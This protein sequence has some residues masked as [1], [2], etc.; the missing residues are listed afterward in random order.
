MDLKLLQNTAILSEKLIELLNVKPK[1]RIKIEYTKKDNKLY[2]IIIKS[3]A[4]NVLS[5]SNTIRCDGKNRDFL[6][7]F[8]TEFDVFEADEKLFLIGNQEFTVFTDVKTAVEQFL[9]LSILTDTN[10]NIQKFNSYI[11]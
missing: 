9:D 4:G 11:I 1:D 6:A 5:K 3:E 2:P 7:Q 10:Y 8:G